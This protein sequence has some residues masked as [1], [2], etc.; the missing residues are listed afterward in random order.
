MENIQKIQYEVLQRQNNQDI[1]RKYVLQYLNDLEKQNDVR[2]IYA[3]ETGSRA[4]GTNV[5]DSDFDVKGY[6]IGSPQ[7]YMSIKGCPEIIDNYHQ[8]IVVDGKELDIDFEFHDIKNFF[9]QKISQPWKPNL[10]YKFFTEEQDIYINLF[11]P[12]QLDTIKQQLNLDQQLWD[13]QKEEKNFDRNIKAKDIVNFI[14][15]LCQFFY[16]LEHNSFPPYK[17]ENL[18]QKL[19][20]D[21]NENYIKYEKVI[22]DEFQKYFKMK[23]EVRLNYVWEG[24]FSQQLI[25]LMEFS[26]KIAKENDKKYYN[27]NIEFTEQQA[28][29]IFQKLL[30]KLF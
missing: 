17:I 5:E 26:Y 3:S 13:Q 24:D 7:K 4:F 21:K 29:Q 14:V 15:Y 23:Q 9:K 30:K 25:E 1:S 20:E 28:E 18:K 2:I 27:K 19:N 11:D 10:N 6:Y 22:N 12:E 8:K 16:I